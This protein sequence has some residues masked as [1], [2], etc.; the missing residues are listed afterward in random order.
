MLLKSKK[1]QNYAQDSVSLDKKLDLENEI[2]ELQYMGVTEL[3]LKSSYEKIKE[4]R[5]FLVRRLMSVEIMYTNGLT[6]WTRTVQGSHV[7]KPWKIVQIYLSKDNKTL[8]TQNNIVA[9]DI[10]KT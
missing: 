9:F 1:N 5:M 7:K 8:I 2:Q 10:A 4:C 3:K 6:L